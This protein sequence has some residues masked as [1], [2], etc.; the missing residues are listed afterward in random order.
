MELARALDF[1]RTTEK[2]ILATMKRDG[3]PQLSNV[4]HFVTADGLVRVSITAGRAKYLNIQRDPRVSL[5]AIADEVRRVGYVCTAARDYAQRGRRE[6]PAAPRC[7]PGIQ[8]ASTPRRRRRAHESPGISWCLRQAAARQ[9]SRD[10]M[11]DHTAARSPVAA[12]P[13]P[14]RR[15]C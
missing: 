6:R 5:H 3:R 13:R 8:G 10:D 12:P 4:S 15:D 14:R 9:R 2:S 7:V 1:A 11:G